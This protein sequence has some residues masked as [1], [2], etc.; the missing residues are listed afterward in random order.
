MYLMQN[1]SECNVKWA[2]IQNLPGRACLHTPYLWQIA[3]RFLSFMTSHRILSA[4]LNI[5]K[6]LVKFFTFVGL[7]KVVQS[8]QESNFMSGL[9]QH[10][11][12]QLGIQHVKSTAYH[13]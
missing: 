12:F 9:F 11:L 13:P 10:V 5:V 3:T 7:S 4:F 1:D 8:D 6:A 2:E